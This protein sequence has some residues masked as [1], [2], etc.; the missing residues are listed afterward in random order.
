MLSL[1]LTNCSECTSIPSLMQD[2]DCKLFELSKNLYNNTV[3][4]LNK[5]INEDAILDLLNYKRILR[6]KFCNSEYA[7]RYSVEQIASKI[8]LLKFK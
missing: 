4:S 6:F 7:S 8:K 5:K 1:K 2:I 3:F